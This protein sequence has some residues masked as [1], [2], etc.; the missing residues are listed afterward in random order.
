[1][2]LI[3]PIIC[4]LIL[5]VLLYFR[6]QKDNKEKTFSEKGSIFQMLSSRMYI[7]LIGGVIAMVVAI[8]RE[9]H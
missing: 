2:N 8:I 5:F 4:L 1:M 6:Y 9:L 7:I 3:K